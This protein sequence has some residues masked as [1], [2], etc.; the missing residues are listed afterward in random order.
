MYQLP[1]YLAW[2]AKFCVIV[3]LETWVHSIITNNL[4]QVDRLWTFLPTLYSAY[5]ALLCLW[6]RRRLLWLVPYVPEELEHAATDLSPRA[7]L[8]FALIVLWMCRYVL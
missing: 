2:P 6:P 7:V 3:T 1:S 8:M 4:S 5:Y